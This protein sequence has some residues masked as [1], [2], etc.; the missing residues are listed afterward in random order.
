MAVKH[1]DR[2]ACPQ[3]SHQALQPSVLIAPDNKPVLTEPIGAIIGAAVDSLRTRILKCNKS[4]GQRD[5][6]IGTRISEMWTRQNGHS[7]LP[8]KVG[9][10]LISSKFHA[11]F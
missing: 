10:T 9:Y 4:A 8:G 6:R 3:F 1:N 2:I 7:P 11:N 5:D